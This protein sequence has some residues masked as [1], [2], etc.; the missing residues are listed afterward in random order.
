MGKI[1]V[2]DGLELEMP[3]RNK[4]GDRIHFYMNFHFKGGVGVD[5]IDC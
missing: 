1:S 5:F 3:K 4:D 2:N